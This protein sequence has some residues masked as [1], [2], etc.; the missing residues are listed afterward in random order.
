MI[1]MIQ[2]NKI[3]YHIILK[4]GIEILLEKD[5]MFKRFNEIKIMKRL[6]I[7]DNE[8]LTLSREMKFK[9]LGL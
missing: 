1:M 7:D 5:D 9:S 3:Y 8:Y 6:F 2:K 4:N